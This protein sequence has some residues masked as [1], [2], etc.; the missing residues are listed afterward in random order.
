[1]FSN[2]D[3]ITL[4]NIQFNVIKVIPDLTEHSDLNID[5]FLNMIPG[6]TFTSQSFLIYNCAF[7]K[8]PIELMILYQGNIFK[9]SKAQN[10]QPLTRSSFFSKSPVNLFLI[11]TIKNQGK[12]IRM[13]NVEFKLEFTLD[14]SF[15]VSKAIDFLKNINFFL[16]IFSGCF[17]F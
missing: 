12:K 2:Y 3:T 14:S 6:F 1:M 8:S 4:R 11:Y 13:Q 7:V 5:L 16:L 17:S 9:D 15:N 10:M